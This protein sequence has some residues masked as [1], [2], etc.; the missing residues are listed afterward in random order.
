[1]LWFASK[2]LYCAISINS[3]VTGHGSLPNAEKSRRSRR[4]WSVAETIE[5]IVNKSRKKRKKFPEQSKE[6]FSRFEWNQLKRTISTYIPQNSSTFFPTC[7]KKHAVT[8]I[9]ASCR[10]QNFGRAVTGHEACRIDRNSTVS[11]I[12]TITRK[13]YFDDCKWECRGMQSS[14]SG[15]TWINNKRHS[16]QSVYL[17]LLLQ[18]FE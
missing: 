9:L 1:M 2:R 10:N 17:E 18:I 15:I 8:A 4:F 5:K 11:L 7:R 16:T 14:L 12:L 6:S 3:A 13:Q